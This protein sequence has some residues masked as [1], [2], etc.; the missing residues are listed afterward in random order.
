MNRFNKFFI[1][2][3]AV[4]LV[5][6]TLQAL[7][8]HDAAK[9]GDLAKVK[10]IV[11][12]EPAMAGAKDETGRTPLHWACRGV[13]IEVVKY[14][15][16]RGVDVN[17]QDNSSVTPLH[18]VCSRGHL[19]AAKILIGAG[20]RVD[21]RMSD[22]STPL[23]SA[24]AQGH[25]DLAVF[26]LE[27][28]APIDVQDGSDDTPLHAA[29]WEARWDVVELLI[30]RMP[31]SA[32]AALDRRDFDGNTVLHLACWAGRRETVELLVS[33]GADLNARNTLGL[34][35]INLAEDRGFG[36]VADFL[37]EA[38]ADRGPR[39]FPALSGPY[40]GQTPPGTTPRL[41]AKGIVSTRGGMYGTITFSPD[42]REAYWKPQSSGKVLYMKTEN[43][44]WSPPREFVF[45]AKET[46][47]VPFYAPD[48]RRLYFMAGSRDA[49]G[50]IEKETIWFVEKTVTGWS[51]PKVFDPVIKS[52]AMHWQFSLDK[53]GDLYFSSGNILCAR[54]EKGRYL[55][56]APLPAPINERH[57][58]AEKYRAGEVGPF[59]SP[60]GDY[61][62]YT[63]FRAN[64]RYAVQLFITFKGRDG[65]WL[66]PQNL[67]ERLAT[68]GNDSAP[69]VTPDG[70]Y[71]F[72]QSNRSDSGVSRGLYWVD[73]SIIEELRP[74]AAK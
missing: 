29:A 19:E 7:E 42:G 47:N 57:T 74:K 59:I 63:K 71:L 60:A 16:E 4:C 68:E 6:P 2:A 73:A 55:A 9:A 25:K 40:I 56:P 46:I 62:I 54:F 23:H 10:A 44:V 65:N 37:A 61:L 45:A 28:G 20:A 30:A 58:E 27:K 51:E 64:A 39:R 5:I 24:A 69:Q 53:K 33:K 50:V 13:H 67:S 36:A 22:Q 21:A 41:F 31:A 12:K 70:K 49:R 15:V 48:G 1:L 52:V 32:K 8:I 72:F 35:A 11:E 38:K 17:A 18:S 66:E 3:L 14:L 26:L 34:A 43:G